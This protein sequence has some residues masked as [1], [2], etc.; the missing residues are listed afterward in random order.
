MR[1][2]AHAIALLVLAAASST[3]PAGASEIPVGEGPVLG[4]HDG[5]WAGLGLAYRLRLE[6]RDNAD[7]EADEEDTVLAGLQRARLELDLGFADWV[8]AFVQL[9]DSRHLG[10]GNSSM[11]YDGNTDLHQAWARLTVA[12]IFSVKVGRQVLAYGDQRL[13]G[14]V[15]WSNVGRVFDGAR[16][17]LDYKLGWIDAFATVFTPHGGGDLTE[18]TWFFGLYD[19]LVLLDGMIAWDQ[20]VL[21]LFD[22]RAALPAGTVQD[23]DGEPVPGPERNLVTLGTRLRLRG[24]GVDAGFEAV[25]QTGYHYAGYGQGDSPVDQSAYALH[26]DFA[27]TFPVATS[28]TLRVEANHASGNDEDPE[29]HWK[30]VHNLFPT[31]HPHYGAMDLMG[32]SNVT[33]GSVGFGLS[34]HEV[35]RLALAYWVFA[36]ASRHDG[37]YSASGREL[38]APPDP[39]VPTEHDDEFML[40]HEVDLTV[41]IQAGEHVS[42]VSGFGAFAPVGYARARGSSPQLWGYSML[43]VAF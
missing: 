14:A 37:W 30:R 33:N 1:S 13:I 21:G 15:D 38:A 6:V 34:P 20:Y 32:W 9:Q 41:R 10:Y 2:H 36:R 16:L 31:N 27:F 22:T 17:S 24:R 3:R 39:L 29:R 12:R 25:Y 26:A 35:L 43:N 23:A 40:G 7:L 4:S 42:V 11:Q 19:S 8:E 28:P 18:G 5:L